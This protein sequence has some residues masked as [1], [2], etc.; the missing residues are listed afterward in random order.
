[1]NSLEKNQVIDN[2]AER[3]NNSSHIYITDTLGLNAGNT[4]NLRKECYKNQVQLVVA[5]NT[6]LKKGQTLKLRYR[7]LVHAGDHTEAGI[8]EQFAKYKQ[9]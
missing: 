5:K 7:I 9:E 8:E 3:I 6:L 1:M 4:V 2:L